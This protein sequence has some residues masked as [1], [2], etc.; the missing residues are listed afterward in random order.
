MTIEL[1]RSIGRQLL[2]SVFGRTLGGNRFLFR[3][4]QRIMLL[5]T[6]HHP[7]VIRRFFKARRRMGSDRK[8]VP[9]WTI[10]NRVVKT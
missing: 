8:N 3:H 9:I 4:A 5:D 1:F 2:I 10:F 7:T 6:V